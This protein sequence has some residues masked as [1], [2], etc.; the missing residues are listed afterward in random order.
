MCELP[1]LGGREE[2]WLVEYASAIDLLTWLAA[3]PG[4]TQCWLP[5]SDV[6][7]LEASSATPPG[8]RAGTGGEEYN[9]NPWPSV[10]ELWVYNGATGYTLD[11]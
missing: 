1:P 6:L 8:S 4:N 10:S 5:P 2:G 9:R 7:P 11:H 3:V